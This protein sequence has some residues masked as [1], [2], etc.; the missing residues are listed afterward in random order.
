MTNRTAQR[1]CL[2]RSSICLQGMSQA[3]TVRINPVS[4]PAGHVTGR[5]CSG[6]SSL[7][8]CRA[9]HKWRDQVVLVSPSAGHVTG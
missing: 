5:D 4:R 9:C 7:Y 6:Y 3:E 2:G 8:A 1:N